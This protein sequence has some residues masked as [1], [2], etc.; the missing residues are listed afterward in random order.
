VSADE[1]LALRVTYGNGQS[2]DIRIQ[3][4]EEPRMTQEEL[5]DLRATDHYRIAK[6]YLT[7]AER[8]FNLGEH[9]ETGLKLAFTSI[10]GLANSILADMD[11]VDRS[12]G[13]D[14]DSIEVAVQ[15]K[16]RDSRAST[17]RFVQAAGTLARANGGQLLT[18]NTSDA[19]IA[20]FFAE[21]KPAPRERELPQHQQFGYDFL[22][23]I[24]LWL[25]SGPGAVI[26]GFSSRSSSSSRLPIPKGADMDAIQEHLIPYLLD[27][28]SD[29]CILNVLF[30]QQR[31]RPSMPLPMPSPYHLRT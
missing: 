14:P 8:M 9:G 18:G 5:N 17:R 11:R 26:E 1:D 25:D 13:V 4:P 27:L 2:E 20:Q 15:N 31:R 6:T 23:A 28:A 29:R 12:W 21:I 10:L 3:P 7:I 24:L 16:L 30:S 19:L 22:K